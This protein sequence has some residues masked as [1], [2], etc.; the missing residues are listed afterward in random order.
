MYT[1]VEMGETRGRCSKRNFARE[2]EG[3]H[4]FQIW[5]VSLLVKLGSG[6]ADR[7]PC[8]EDRDT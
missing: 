4:Y 2:I 8:V 6:D 5:S 1:I 3:T 7:L